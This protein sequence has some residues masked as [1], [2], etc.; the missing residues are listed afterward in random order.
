MRG[1]REMRLWKD[2]VREQWGKR[3]IKIPRQLWL[4]TTFAFLFGTAVGW[5]KPSHLPFWVS[6]ISGVSAL[7][8]RGSLLGS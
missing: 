5:P 4:R 6:E 2:C 3:A 7:K 8:E 1:M